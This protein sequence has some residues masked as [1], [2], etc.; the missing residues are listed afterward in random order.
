MVAY[1]KAE[2][3]A[4]AEVCFLLAK[5]LPREDRMT[6][7]YLPR[8]LK[9]SLKVYI[10]SFTIWKSAEQL[11]EGRLLS[12][13]ESAL[14][15]NVPVTIRLVSCENNPAFFGT[16]SLYQCYRLRQMVHT[17]QLSLWF[18]GPEFLK[19]EPAV[20]TVSNLLSS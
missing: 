7:D 20:S 9:K 13:F 2:D 15:T 14:T 8:F 16:D 10:L 4:R 6:F 11:I 12:L 3:G 5:Y 1:N 17:R 18:D 19:T